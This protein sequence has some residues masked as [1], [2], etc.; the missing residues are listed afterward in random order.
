MPTSA[1]PRVTGLLLAAG[2]GRRMGMPK[3]LV[4][5]DGVPWV[6]RAA[7][8]LLAGGCA[9]VVVVLGAAEQ[10]ARDALAGVGPRVAAVACPAWAEGMGE[11]LRTGLAALRERSA[12]A[13]LVHLVDLPD[14]GP[15]VVRR[16]LAAAAGPAAL[17][18]AAYDGVPG[19]PVLLGAD[20]FAG[21]AALAAGDTGAREYLR[22]HRPAVVEC[23]DLAGGLDVDAPPRP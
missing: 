21:V 7:D 17:A 10:E 1:P 5:T 16:M 11:S 12:G 14:V 18:R 20:H 6:R 8:V 2:A 22:R 15:A 23:G 9:D 19:H 13:A 3:A 4:V